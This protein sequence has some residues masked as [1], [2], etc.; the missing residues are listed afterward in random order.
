VTGII[1]AGGTGTPL[2]PLTLVLSKQLLPR[3]RQADN[4]LS[5]EYTDASGN[6]RYPDHH[7]AAGPG[8]AL[9]IVSLYISSGVMFVP[10][11]LPEVVRY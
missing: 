5:L 3:L 2:Y 6:P 7:D 1:L 4:L 9:N 8:C 11:F 10:D